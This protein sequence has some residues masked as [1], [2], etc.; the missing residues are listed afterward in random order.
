MNDI[1]KRKRRFTTLHKRLKDER[2]FVKSEKDQLNVLNE[3][4]LALSQNLFCLEWKNRQR[5]N[6]VDRLITAKAKPSDCSAT[7]RFIDCVKFEDSYGYLNY[8]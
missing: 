6:N 5:W 3:K 8:E 7:S 1:E 4:V 2:L